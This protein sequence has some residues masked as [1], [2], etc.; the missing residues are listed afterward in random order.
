MGKKEDGTH[1]F[2]L[3]TKY[4]G[5]QYIN[6]N[7]MKAYIIQEVSWYDSSDSKD[8]EKYYCVNGQQ[9]NNDS[10]WDLMPIDPDLCLQIQICDHNKDI[11]LSNE[12]GKI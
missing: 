1:Y 4:K 9:K 11:L 6:P 5:L 8:K 7:A 3:V 12:A 10:K 2:H